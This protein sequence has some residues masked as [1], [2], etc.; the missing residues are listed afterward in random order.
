MPPDHEGMIFV[1]TGFA[2]R[3]ACPFEPHVSP[4][5]GVARKIWVQ[6]PFSAKNRARSGTA[7][8]NAVQDLPLF[9]LPNMNS[10]RVL[11]PPDREKWEAAHPRSI[12]AIRMGLMR[13][14]AIEQRANRG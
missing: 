13:A 8:S 2:E 11:L 5:G 7:Y 3:H 12:R 1:F 9:E 10:I 4:G 14:G 6:P